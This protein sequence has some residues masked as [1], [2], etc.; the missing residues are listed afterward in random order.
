MGAKRLIWYCRILN[1]HYYG[2]AKGHPSTVDDTVDKHAVYTLFKT[3]PCL[4]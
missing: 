4:G 1:A 2:D 3:S